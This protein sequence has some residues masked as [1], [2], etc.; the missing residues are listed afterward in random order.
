MVSLCDRMPSPDALV[1]RNSS[2]TR[3]TVETST[4]TPTFNCDHLTSC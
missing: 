4:I 3:T 1:I 2:V